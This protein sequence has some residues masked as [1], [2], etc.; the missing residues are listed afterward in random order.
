MNIFDAFQLRYSARA[1]QNKSVS[2]DDLQRILQAANDA[3][4]AGNRQAYDIVVVRDIE[5]KRKLVKAAWDQTFIAEA[6]VVLVFLT[7]P[8]RNRERYGE[9][10]ARLYAVQDATVAC[11][12]AQLAATALGLATC[13]VG[14]YDDDAVAKTVGAAVFSQP[15]AVL[16]I[17]YA[18]DT[19]RP[20]SR[21]PLKDL[22]HD[23]TA[24]Q[25]V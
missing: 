21:R 24:N 25:T 14:A 8:G 11:A 18:A 3:P 16:P 10:G 9:R 1:Y 13:W 15:V 19:A 2:E 17:G 22:I 23:E 7:N 6:P 5:R 12:Y 20:R 4:S